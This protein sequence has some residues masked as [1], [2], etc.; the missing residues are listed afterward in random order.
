MPT[1]A[2]PPVNNEMYRRL[3]HAWW[4][5]DVGEFCTI[6]LFM[7]PVRFGYFERVLTGEESLERGQLR[8][9]DVGCG[10]GLLAEEL[11]RRGFEVT[12]ID[13]APESIETARKHASAS[14]LSIDYEVG[15]GEALPFPDGQFDHVTCCDVLEHVDDVDRVIAEVARVLRPGG[16][17]LYDTINRTFVSKL[18]VIK[19]MQEWKSTAFFGEANLHV[20]ERFIKPT[21]LCDLLQ[22]HALEPREMRG[23]APRSRNLFSLWRDFRRRARGKMSFTELGERLA[24]Q[25]TSHLDGSYMGYASKPGPNTSP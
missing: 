24:F 23:I 10:G 12:G 21:E 18:V 13:P 11:A 1:R 22:A 25:E 19:L 16:L 9:L 7:N 14:G 6:R 17:F 4:D 8:V 15:T 3:G 20:W 5:D 2:K